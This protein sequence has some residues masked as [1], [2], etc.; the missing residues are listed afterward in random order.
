MEVRG[1]QGHGLF[2]VRIGCLVP[3]M[4]VC[5]VVSLAIIRIEGCLNSNL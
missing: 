1:F 3:R 4:C 2:I 5:G